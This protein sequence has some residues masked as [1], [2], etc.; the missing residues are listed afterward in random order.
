ME[1]KTKIIEVL[2]ELKYFFVQHNVNVWTRRTELAIQQINEGKINTTTILKDFV[3][4]GM[5]SLIDLYICSDN[6]HQI[7]L[8][9][10]DT[11][12]Q[13]EKLTEQ[14]LKIKNGLDKT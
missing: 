7:K 3:G 14:I 12:K 6:G 8:C 5:G 11:N 9:E 13:L 4:A 10:A 2:E 1:A